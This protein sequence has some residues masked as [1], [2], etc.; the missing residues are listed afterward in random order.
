M[1]GS[2]RRRTPLFDFSTLPDAL[3]TS[4]RTTAW[5]ELRVRAG[6]VRHLDLE[7]DSPR[8]ERVAAGEA[9]VIVSGIEH[10]V[11]PSTDA[12][13]YV[14]FSRE[15]DAAMIPGDVHIDTRG[16]RDQRRVRWPGGRIGAA[17]SSPTT[18]S[19]WL[20]ASSEGPPSGAPNLNCGRST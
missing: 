14:Q 3:A 1:R 17:T 4:L 16:R 15:L 12:R 5:A 8:Y 9:A 11:E 10:H 7:G 13:F 18:M 6:T 2:S 19:R 20:S